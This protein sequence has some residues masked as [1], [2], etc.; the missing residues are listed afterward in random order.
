MKLRS[1]LVIISAASSMAFLAG[2][3]QAD[4]KFP[5]GIRVIS[6][7]SIEGISNSATRVAGVFYTGNSIGIPGPNTNDGSPSINGFTR[8][9]GLAD[10]P[11][12][13]DDVQWQITAG[14]YVVI[15]ECGE[16]MTSAYVPAGGTT[17]LTT[18][19]VFSA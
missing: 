1:S 6:E 3:N 19:Y 17:F 2:C 13:E 14:W 4:P 16:P 7:E 10:N 18:C 15:P 11:D 9:R 8:S 12:A 5:G